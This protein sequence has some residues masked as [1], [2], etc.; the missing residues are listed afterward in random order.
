MAKKNSPSLFINNKAQVEDSIPHKTNKTKWY[1]VEQRK[2]DKCGHLTWWTIGTFWYWPEKR[3]ESG[4]LSDM[5]VLKFDW[6]EEFSKHTTKERNG[7]CIL[8]DILYRYRVEEKLWIL[9]LWYSW[10]VMWKDRKRFWWPFWKK[11]RDR[12]QITEVYPHPLWSTPNQEQ[13]G[14]AIVN[15]SHYSLVSFT[16]K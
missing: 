16:L 1:V 6:R 8:R 12:I 7:R 15:W 10:L 11:W 13:M 3:I 5:S 2:S 4:L 9:M 14:H